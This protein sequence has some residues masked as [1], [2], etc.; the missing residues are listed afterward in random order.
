VPSEW[1]VVEQELFEECGFWKRFTGEARRPATHWPMR[2]YWFC[3]ALVRAVMLSIGWYRREPRKPEP[4]QPCDIL[5]IYMTDNQRRA[6][7]P[8]L[9]LTARVQTASWMSDADWEISWRRCGALSLRSLLPV[10]RLLM[11]RGDRE[12]TIPWLEDFVRYRVGLQLASDLF[13]RAKP[14]VIVVSNDHSGMYRAFL[15]VAR[16]CGCRI[17]YTQ[18]ASIGKNFPPLNFDLT[19]LDGV[20][21]YLQYRASGTP[22]GPIVITGRQRPT[23]HGSQQ[24]SATDLRLG[25]AT[26]WDDSLLE[27]IPLLHRVGKQLPGA[28]LRCHPAETRKYVWRFLCRLCGIRVDSGSLDEFLR[29]TSVLISGMSG[30]ILDAA[31]QGVPCLMKL[32]A[33]RATGTVGDYYGY[34]KFGLC[35]PFHDLDDLQALVASRTTQRTDFERVGAYEAGLVQVPDEEKRAALDLFIA[36]LEDGRDV[37]GELAKRYAR[38]EH[39]GV[40]LFVSSEYAGLCER[41]GWLS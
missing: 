40:E 18:H 19:M 35:K 34:E 37:R 7:S 23:S 41:Y 22:R 5:L 26:N 38:V 28:V 15:R 30:I 31:L 39:Q 36:S 14:R 2:M 25:L 9:R 10:Y 21:A 29:A 3:R 24:A 20:Q 4:S 13:S 11:R 17:V 33:V 8:W 1:A 16:A 27:W 6:I 32:P 12:A